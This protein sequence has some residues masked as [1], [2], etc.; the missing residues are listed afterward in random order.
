[1]KQSN[2]GIAEREVILNLNPKQNE[3]FTLSLEPYLGEIKLELVIGALQ[4]VRAVAIATEGLHD[5]FPVPHYLTSLQDTPQDTT[6]LVVKDSEGYAVYFCLSHRDQLVTLK[7]NLRGGVS[8]YAKSGTS[9]EANLKRP[10]LIALKGVNLHQTLE[11]VI[12]HALK[13]THGMGKLTFQKNFLSPWM[14]TLGWESGASLRSEVSHEKI[15]QKV[16]NM[17]AFGYQPGFVLIDEGWQD[18]HSQALKSFEAD[19][20][21][22]PKGLKG[23]VQDLRNLGIHY[24][25]VWHGM[26]GYRGGVEATLARKYEFPPDAQGRYFLGYDVGHTFEFFHDYYTY[27]RDQG[28]SFVKVGDQASPSRFC[29]EGMDVTSLH[30][31]LQVSIQAAA[32]IHFNGMQLNTDCLRNEN[33]YYWTTSNIARV[34][35]DIDLQNR[36]DILK[37]IRNNLMNSMWM[38]HLMQPDF[39]AWKTIDNNGESLAIFHALSGSINI[40]SDISGEHHRNY[41]KKMML[42]CGTILKADRPLSLCQDS[43]FINPLEERQVYK[44]FTRKNNSGILAVFNILEGNRSLHGEISPSEVEGLKGDL[45]AVLSYH[46]GFLGLLRKEEY[47]KISLKPHQNDIFT[48][49]PVERGVAVL[50]CYSFFLA[51]GPIVE[52]NVEE[53]SMYISSL[54]AAPI[55]I[56]CEKQILEVKRNGM[57][58]PWEYDERRKALTLEGRA[59]MQNEAALYHVTFEN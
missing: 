15:L 29:R 16:E 23:L 6:L 2:L 38:Q 55:I 3:P 58:I 27:L 10:A 45:F 26:M 46:N 12:A 28:I 14:Q 54:V 56:Y 22:F 49:T 40:V 52:V 44:A 11:Q 30:R 8:L 19:V 51:P 25:G 7:G 24:V 20:E 39:D 53:D 9:F 42:P 34:A 33:L 13:L 1:M 36:Q 32:S 21:R 37:S 17:R 59:K 41:I 18:V 5:S 43:F 50:G 4:G 47:L 31:N 57:T 35:K 48:F